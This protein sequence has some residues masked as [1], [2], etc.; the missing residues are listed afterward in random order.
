MRE[1]ATLRQRGVDILAS[2][3][4]ASIALA[5]WLVASSCAACKNE[6]LPWAEIRHAAENKQTTH[7]KHTTRR[8]RSLGEVLPASSWIRAA[9]FFGGG[10]HHMRR[11][12]MCSL[13]LVSLDLSFR[14][15]EREG[16][17]RSVCAHSNVARKGF[18]HAEEAEEEDETP[19]SP[20][21]VFLCSIFLRVVVQERCYNT[22]C[23]LP[24]R[25][26]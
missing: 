19:F 9:Y 14:L 16:L 8:G 18:Y 12:V 25:A 23:E 20:F 4:T 2:L 17:C 5:P 13:R 26:M 22:C 1:E 21:F 24:P 11:H 7:T 15:R 6:V 10:E 3:A